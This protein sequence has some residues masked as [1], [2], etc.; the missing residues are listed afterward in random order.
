MCK[1]GAGSG[2]AEYRAVRI[3][4]ATGLLNVAKPRASTEARRTP[5]EWNMV[6]E[7]GKIA[8]TAGHFKETVSRDLRIF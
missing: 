1:E 4:Q 2:W 3:R 5:D 7:E 6:P 8:R